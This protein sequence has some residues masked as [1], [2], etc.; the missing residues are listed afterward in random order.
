MIF[1]EYIASILEVRPDFSVNLDGDK[2]F[3]VSV[4]FHAYSMKLHYR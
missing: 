2:A 4:V 1:T 3:K